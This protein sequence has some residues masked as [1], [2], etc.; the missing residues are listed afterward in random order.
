MSG[1]DKVAGDVNKTAA[2]VDAEVDTEVD[3]AAAEEI[4]LG[5]FV[6]DAR[7]VVD[8]DVASRKRLF[9]QMAKLAVARGDDGPDLDSVLRALTRREKLGCTGI[10]NGI[11]L[12]HGRIDG[13]QNPVVAIARLKTAIPYDAPDGAPV[14]LAVCLLAPVCANGIHL[15][16]LAALA[17][18]FHSPA[19]RESLQR[20][21]SAAELAARFKTAPGTNTNSAAA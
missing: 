16:L 18:R 11:A 12:P 9:E 7:V 10:G 4:S 15:R 6:D 17:E 2:E 14:W 20:A 8:L 21:R 3:G 1:A 19:F 13:F 5:D